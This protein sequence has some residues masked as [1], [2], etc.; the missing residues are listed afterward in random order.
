[1][2]VCPS[3]SAEISPTVAACPSCG[4]RLAP[5]DVAAG[6]IPA[7][8][9]M[10]PA[11]RSPPDVLDE[12]GAL[13]AYVGR[14]ADYYLDRWK[15][16]EVRKF[17]LSWNWAA[18]LGGLLWMVYRKMCTFAAIYFAVAM[19]LSVLI[20]RLHVSL[21]FKAVCNLAVVVFVGLNANEWYRQHVQRR[22]EAIVRS[23]S[24][25]RRRQMLASSGGT[26]L[27]GAL[28]LGAVW[29]IWL[30]ATLR[31]LGPGGL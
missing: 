19:A 4:Q 6:A 3:C 28:A 16:S 26:N 29:A 17:R 5:L 1:M 20:E 2:R 7:H 10:A 21:T 11:D 15:A 14:N 30:V 22:V 23:S 12:E 9:A 18:F 13:R 31:T 24:S 8:G 25:T 27:L